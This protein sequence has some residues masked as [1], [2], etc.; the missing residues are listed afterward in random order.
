MTDVHEA[1]ESLGELR[2]RPAGLLRLTVPRLGY[3]H[4][5]APRLAAFLAAYPEIDLDLS[6]DDAFVDIVEQGF[7]AGLRIGEMVERDMIGVRVSGRS[8]VRRRR[9][10]RVLRGARQAEAP[11]RP[12]RPRLHQLSST[13]D[14]RRL[15]LGVHRGRQGLRDCRQRPDP[16]QRRR[17]HG[18]AASR[19]SASPTSRDA[20]REHLAA[21]RLVRVLEPFCAPFPGFFL[22][23]PS[24]AHLAPK[25]QALVDFLRVRR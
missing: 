21:K 18:E 23:Y 8:A 11:T 3:V 2:D 14:W 13:R 7:D 24:R 5:L 1:F 25:L 19:G 4:V 16:A 22:Y 10:A 17:S 6:I 15:P 9:L 12:S 20:V